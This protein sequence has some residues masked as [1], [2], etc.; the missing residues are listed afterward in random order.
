MNFEK[1]YLSLRRREGH[2]YTNEEVAGLP[3]TG[4]THPCFSYWAA[5]KRS[6]A[7]LLEYIRGKHRYQRI[8]EVGCGNGWLSAKMAAIPKTMVTG[9]DINLAELE[10]A[11]SVFNGRKNLAFTYG[12]IRDDDFL[13]SSFNIIVFGDSLSYFPSVYEIIHK[14]LSLLPPCGEIHIIDT[15]FARK[16]QS[17]SLAEKSNQYF[18][19]LGVPCMNDYFYH[20][21]LDEVEPFRYN[22]LHNPSS[23]LNRIFRHDG[24]LPW[25]RITK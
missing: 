8:L 9:I 23:M 20:H 15:P 1:Q 22:I 17:Q 5:R 4:H 14:A 24:G 7:R 6:A 11:I 18:T 25:I 12:D 13:D 21:F 19:S 10:Q 2:V 3:E 16:V